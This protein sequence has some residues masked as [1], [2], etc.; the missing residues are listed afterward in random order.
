[1]YYQEISMAYA[2]NCVCHFS[3]LRTAKMAVKNGL[4]R[5]LISKGCLRETVLSHEE[6]DEPEPV[7]MKVL[8]YLQ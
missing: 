7:E 5:K 2:G 6:Q 8:V 4:A 3:L 1:M